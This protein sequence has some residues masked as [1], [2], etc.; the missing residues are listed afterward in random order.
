[1]EMSFDK[2]IELKKCHAKGLWITAGEMN[3]T[4]GVWAAQ[5]VGCIHL[6]Q[7]TVQPVVD[8]RVEILQAAS[9]KRIENLSA[10]P[11]LLEPGVH[12]I[13]V[14][15]LKQE[16]WHRGRNLLV[17]SQ[18]RKICELELKKHTISRWAKDILGCVCVYFS[19]YV[20]FLQGLHSKTLW[21]EDPSNQSQ[22]MFS[23][24]GSEPDQLPNSRQGLHICQLEKQT[25][26]PIPTQTFLPRNNRL[27]NAFRVT[28]TKIKPQTSWRCCGASVKYCHLVVV[29]QYCIL[30]GAFNHLFILTS[31]SKSLM[32]P[33][34]YRG[35]K[36]LSRES[37][38]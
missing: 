23:F 17:F 9:V 25:W 12:L 2:I 10:C 7:V 5:P 20:I 37:L 27:D 16:I 31:S 19:A 30:L 29:W 24:S 15:Q 28:E 13:R 18:F 11:G 33:L 6:V 21:R 3:L 34:K 14:F 38:L 35:G 1:M 4:V 26:P 22:V 32:S 8:D 36:G